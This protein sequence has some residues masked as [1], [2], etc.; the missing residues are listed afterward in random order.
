MGYGKLLRN[1]LL[2]LEGD[3]SKVPEPVGGHAFKK[4][5]GRQWMMSHEEKYFWRHI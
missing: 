4:A 5:F 2:I 1:V 3:R